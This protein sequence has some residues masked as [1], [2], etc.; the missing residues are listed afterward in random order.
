MQCNLIPDEALFRTVGSRIVV[1]W[2]LS[3]LV[4]AAVMIVWWTIQQGRISVLS[5]YVTNLESEVHHQGG[6]SGELES[7]SQEQLVLQERL[8]RM[9]IGPA[10]REIPL[11]AL[12]SIAQL[13]PPEMWI[14]EIRLADR[15]MTVAG[16]T[17]GREVFGTFLDSLQ[18]VRCFDS[19]R[20]LSIKHAARKGPRVDEFIISVQTK[21]DDGGSSET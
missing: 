14:R 9:V 12:I 6:A 3:T 8:Q 19:V 11:R 10:E 15:K 17:Q 18:A 16:F 21:P 4:P 20:V 7:S 5:E 2:W 13:L 1:R